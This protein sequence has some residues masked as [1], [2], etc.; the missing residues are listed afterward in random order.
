MEKKRRNLILAVTVL[1]TVGFLSISLVSYYAARESLHEQVSESTLP[2]TSDNI[3]SEIQRDLVR[4]IFLSSLMAVDTFVRDWVLEGENDEKRM[5]HYLTAIQQRYGAV[6]SYFVSEKTRRY[7][8]TSGIIKTVRENDP[9][10]KWFFR[11]RSMKEDYEINIDRDTANLTSLT[12]FINYRVYG[13]SGEFIGATGVGL[14]LKAVKALIDDYERRYGRQIF[15]ID[16]DGGVT[17]HGERYQGFL[18]IHDR[19]G[20]KKIA[21]KILAFPG[22]AFSYDLDGKKFFVNSRFVPEFKWFLLVEQAGDMNGKRILNTLWFNILIACAVTGVV[23]FLTI[24]TVRAYQRQL[25]DTISRDKLTGA[26]SR[27]VF[28]GVL[29]QAMK[30]AKR[31]DGLLSLAMLD[32]DHFKDVNDTHGHLAGDAVL[33]TVVENVRG[34]IRETDALCRWGGEEFLLMFDRCDIGQARDLAEKIRT[35]IERSSVVFSGTPITVTVSLGIAQFVPGETER[36]FVNRVDKALFAAK[37]GGRN[38]VQA[39][40]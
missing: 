4:P 25:E 17:L 18:N 27:Q 37:R 20:I 36:D 7:Y 6:T 12:V 8:H 16:R 3:Y 21:A 30:V 26:L 35:A 5:I 40:P 28:D 39:A 13:P 1:L 31:E 32:I 14:A 29:D 15:F 10:D 38:Q 2:L 23:L 22:G 9:Q 34:A 24:L 19:P 11:V 33:R